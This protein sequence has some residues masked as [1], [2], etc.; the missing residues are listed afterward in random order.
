MCNCNR[1]VCDMC[2]KSEARKPHKHAAIIK[3][4]ADGAEI[5]FRIQ[6]K[7]DWLDITALSPSFN[8]DWQY[9]VKPEKKKCRMKAFKSLS[10]GDVIIAVS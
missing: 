1:P 7:Y 3:A 4:W 2:N 10:P 8:P 9:R 5:Q 6:E